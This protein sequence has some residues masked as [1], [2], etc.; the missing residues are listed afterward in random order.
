MAMKPFPC[1][2]LTSLF[3]NS[4]NEIQRCCFSEAFAHDYWHIERSSNS[5]SGW[6]LLDF[7]RT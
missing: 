3:V 2:D 7:R 1:L 5:K 4:N 6:K